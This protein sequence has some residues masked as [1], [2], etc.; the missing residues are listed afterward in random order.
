MQLP[1]ECGHMH[2]TWAETYTFKLCQHCDCD[3]Y[4]PMED[5]LEYLI[6]KGKKKGLIP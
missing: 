2:N 4:S 6:W 3:L 1:C 5:N